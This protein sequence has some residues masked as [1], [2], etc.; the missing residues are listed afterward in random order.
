[1]PGHNLPC[2]REDLT[3]RRSRR[4]KL[5]ADLVVKFQHRD[6]CLR[7]QKILVVAMIADQCESFGAARQI[8]AMITGHASEWNVNILADQQ[9]RTWILPVRVAGITRVKLSAAI[10]TEA[11]DIVVIERRRAEILN[12][13][14]VGFLV[15]ERSEIQ[16]D[17]VID[18][19]PEIGESRWDLG[20]VSGDIVRIRVRHRVSKFLQRTVVDG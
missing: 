6:M 15:T 13:V 17:I 9:F 11:I 3:R 19:L 4:R 10:R 7:D 1:M 16:R 20:V 18:K 5:I 12:R 14:G 2:L 8:V